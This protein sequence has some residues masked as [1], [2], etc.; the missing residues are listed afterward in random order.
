MHMKMNTYENWD[1]LKLKSYSPIKSV[2]E[3]I[4]KAPSNVHS[5]LKK[6]DRLKAKNEL[7][8]RKQKLSDKIQKNHLYKIYDK[9]YLKLK[10]LMRQQ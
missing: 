3:N 2:F 7:S 5:I 6:Y 9:S 1:Q 4:Q 8:K 10:R